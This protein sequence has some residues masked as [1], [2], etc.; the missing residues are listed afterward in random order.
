[1]NK[2]KTSTR[3]GSLGSGAVTGLAMAVQT[4]LAGIVGIVVARDFGRTAVTDGFF[5]A[6][7]VFVVVL[8]AANGIRVIVLPPLARARDE[9]R[10]GSEVAAYALTLA[11]FVVPLLLLAILAAR[12][13]AWLLT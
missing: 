8:L 12:Q 4:G 5:A 2:Q 9:S 11:A 6:Y 1:M 3:L 10:L 13:C 7:A